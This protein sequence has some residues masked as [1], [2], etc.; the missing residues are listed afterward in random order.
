MDREMMLLQ[1]RQDF[2]DMHKGLVQRK[3]C[4]LEHYDHLARD[5]RTMDELNFEFMLEFSQKTEDI[6]FLKMWEQ[7]SAHIQQV[8][9][10]GQWTKRKKEGM[11]W[12]QGLITPTTNESE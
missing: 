10:S 3:V 2:I 5:L 9:K 11:V 4:T 8:K 12:D 7:I 6:P 1:A